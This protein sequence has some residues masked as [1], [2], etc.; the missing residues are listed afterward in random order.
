MRRGKCIG[1]IG[2]KWGIH[3]PLHKKDVHG[4]VTKKGVGGGGKNE[5]AK[6]AR[7]WS[8]SP[9]QALPLLETIF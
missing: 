3:S 9:P 2:K 1:R 4:L 8:P 7:P 5:H 6:K